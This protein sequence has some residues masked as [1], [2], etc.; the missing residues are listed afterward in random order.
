LP[1]SED[2]L[3]F[4]VPLLLFEEDDRLLFTVPLLLF[5]DDDRL[6]FTVPLLLDRFDDPRFTVPRL[7]ELLPDRLLTV[8]D[9]LERVVPLDRFTVPRLRV[10][11]TFLDRAFER[12][13]LLFAVFLTLASDRV[14][15][16]VSDPRELNPLL[17]GP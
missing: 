7:L 4:T 15:R 3:L 10:V 14:L 17:L 2:R 11:D 13:S 16:I 8:D 1:L 12:I 9:D 6:R 5:E